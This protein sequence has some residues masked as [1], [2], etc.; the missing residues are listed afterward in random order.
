V[1][2][3]KSD[4]K[5]APL[6]R[7][8]RFNKE[9]EL[10]DDDEPES[11]CRGFRT[12]EPPPPKP[13][14]SCTAGTCRSG[15]QGAARCGRTGCASPT[16]SK[17]VDHACC[18]DRAPKNPGKPPVKQENAARTSNGSCGCQVA[19]SSPNANGKCHTEILN[20]KPSSP[21]P[22]ATGV[23]SLSGRS[24]E[25]LG[26]KGSSI[27]LDQLSSCI[28]N[29][30][31]SKQDQLV[32]AYNALDSVTDKGT[33]ADCIDVKCCDK[34]ATS[35]ASSNSLD[36]P[37]SAKLETGQS[38]DALENSSHVIG[39]GGKELANDS[40]QEKPVRTNHVAETTNLDVE[41]A[42]ESGL[43]T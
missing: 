3:V 42:T 43:R 2:S 27:S 25:N 1:R 17:P 36:R 4:Y 41:P 5:K 24:S 32:H 34:L 8:N 39:H 21:S 18:S 14:G 22:I 33:D 31:S 35:L 16:A 20:G 11:C 26:R 9:E 12:K 30:T 28:K 19:P 13:Q 38:S 37:A 7:Q 6:S 15:P 10:I 29:G 23:N 40:L